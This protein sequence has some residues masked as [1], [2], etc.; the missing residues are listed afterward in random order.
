[1]EDRGTVA[2]EPSDLTPAAGVKHVDAAVLR[3]RC[4]ITGIGTE[5]RI[6]HRPAVCLK[7]RNLTA[8]RYIPEVHDTITAS[9]HEAQCRL[10]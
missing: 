9:G 6:L 5:S 2:L 3:G 4:N 10:D 1:M 7:L 8:A